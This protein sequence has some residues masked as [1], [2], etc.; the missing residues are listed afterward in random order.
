MLD[1]ISLGVSDLE[2]SRAFYQVALDPLGMTPVY[3]FDDATGYGR[4]GNPLFW[5]GRASDASPEQ[6][7]HIAFKAESHD[8]VHA[9]HEAAMAA[10]ATDNGAPGPRPQYSPTYYAAFV[11]DFDGHHIEAV[12][13]RGE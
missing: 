1:H 4:D 2:C 7:L 8:A 3:E 5:I 6:G 12:C 11:I 9:F 13:R 10:G